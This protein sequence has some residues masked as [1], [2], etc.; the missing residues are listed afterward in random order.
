[1]AHANGFAAGCYRLHLESLTEIADVA[2]LDFAGHGG[3]KGHTHFSSWTFF[4]EQILGLIDHLKWNS[5]SLIGHSLG[6]ACSL[7]AAM[8]RPDLINKVI[9]WDPVLL[10]PAIILLGKFIDIP[11]AKA[12]RSRRVEFPSIEK[13]CKVLRRHAS[14]K[15]W[16]ND[17]YEDYLKACYKVNQ[18]GVAQ[19]CCDPQIESKIF[20][21]TE[22]R[23]YYNLKNIKTEVCF[24]LPEP[25]TVCPPQA[26]NRVVQNQKK[27]TVYRDNKWNHFFPF[28]NPEQTIQMTRQYLEE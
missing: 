11:L 14:F 6:G 27:A 3:S 28:E 19:L 4:S 7:R 2:A 18:R 26:V 10:S 8:S 5:V 12:A 24:M 22:F 1:M 16:S 15:R 9:A 17:V 23:P 13:V 20:S 25:S 21:I